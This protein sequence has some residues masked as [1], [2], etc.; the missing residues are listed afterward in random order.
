MVESQFYSKEYTYRF[1]TTRLPYEVK[2]HILVWV[3]KEFSS[4]YVCSMMVH[5]GSR[6]HGCAN[7]GPS[8]D[9]ILFDF[10][11]GQLRNVLHYHLL[12]GRCWVAPSKIQIWVKNYSAPS[13]CPSVVVCRFL[14]DSQSLIPVWL[15]WARYFCSLFYAVRILRVQ[16]FGDGCGSPE[17]DKA[18]DRLFESAGA[19]E[20]EAWW[21]WVVL[22]SLFVFSDSLLLSFFVR[23]LSNSSER[24]RLLQDPPFWIRNAIKSIASWGEYEFVRLSTGAFLVEMAVC[25]TTSNR[26]N[27]IVRIRLNKAMDTTDTAGPIGQFLKISH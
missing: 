14:C 26:D 16:E 3:A 2:L 22:I 1:M 17:A 10:F 13:I 18:C 9:N 23:K 4:Y 6:H 7:S 11:P 8:S 12:H 24:P 20:D 19:S 25:I 27:N 21:S 15:R 5:D